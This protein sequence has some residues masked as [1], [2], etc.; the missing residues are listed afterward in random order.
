MYLALLLSEFSFFSH[1]GLQDYEFNIAAVRVY[2]Y[3]FFFWPF[4]IVYLALFLSELSLFLFFGHSG[5]CIKHC[6][7]K[8]LFIYFFG[9]S[10]LCI[11]HCC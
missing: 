9:H 3:F 1:S 6:C 8:S 10:G 7:C 11:K 2:Y 5:L 4:R